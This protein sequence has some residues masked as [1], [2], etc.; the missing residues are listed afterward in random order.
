MSS[1]IFKKLFPQNEPLKLL[2]E[3]ALLLEDAVKILK[4]MFES[5]FKNDNIDLHVN[6]I[7][8]L[9]SRADDIKFQIRKIIGTGIKIPFEKSDFLDYLH[10][11][12][13]LIDCTKD[14]AKKLSL[15]RVILDKNIIDELFILID[16][17]ILLIDYLE[18]AIRSMKSLLYFS[19]SDKESNA[20]KEEIMLVEKSES[21]VDNLSIE[22][23]KKL[24]LQKNK[25]NPIDLIFIEN[26][27]LILSEMGD[28]AENAAELLLNFIRT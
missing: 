9:E 7:C 11:Q 14:L 18:N 2:I 24:Y 4:P 12:E 17:V 22:I 21:K 10:N 27:I 23:A 25:M 3:H 6:K 28:Y 16:E 8:I 13:H 5:Y 26:V 19:F 15:N 20:E 1:S